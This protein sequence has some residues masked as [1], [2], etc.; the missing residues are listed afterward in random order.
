MTGPQ[1]AAHRFWSLADSSWRQEVAQPVYGLRKPRKGSVQNMGW[2]AFS[3]RGLA[4][5]AQY[6][7]GRWYRA[8]FLN[9]V[10]PV[11]LYGTNAA[12]KKPSGRPANWMLPAAIS[13]VFHGPLG[14][15]GTSFLLRD[16]DS[17]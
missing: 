15:M 11:V 2:V 9:R 7:F 14:K 5:R 4:W 16:R 8:Q 3:S 12:L 10:G 1:S 6:L 17:G 13:R